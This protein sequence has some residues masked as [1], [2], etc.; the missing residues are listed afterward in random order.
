MTFKSIQPWI[1]RGLRVML[2]LVVPI[3]LVLVGLRIYAEGGREQVTENAYVKT[4][5]IAMSSAVT[6]RV[7]EVFVKDDVRV[8]K[9][10]ALFRIDSTPYELTAA[11]AK[12]Q[13]DVVRTEMQ[14][15]KAEYRSVVV[16]AEE[17]KVRIEFFAKQVE[18]QEKLRE[19]GMSRADQYDEARQ[20]LD[21][22]K[23]R[24]QTIMEQ[25]RRVQASLGGDLNAP[26]EEHPRFKEA[27][28][29]Y[30]AAVFELSK[31][32]VQSLAEGIVSN[33]KL[34]AGEWVNRG[35]T[36]FSLIDTSPPWVEANFKETQLTHMREGQAVTVVADAYPDAEFK[37]QVVAIAPASGAEFAV[38]PPQNA[39][40]NWVKVVQR[41]P[42]RIE[43]QQGG[44]LPMLRAGMTVTASVET[45]HMRGL[46]RNIQALIDKGYLPQFLEP[47]SALA[48]NAR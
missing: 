22:A 19:R 36:V 21:G 4:N 2:V 41:I 24:L 8:N 46:P 17:V 25:G 31:T 18:R 6:G 14:T 40:G 9:G 11:K 35:Q 13:M 10:D 5:I 20:N 3:G 33:M 42:V 34:E 26:V 16:E 32:T 45:G 7:L 47:S 15:L 27:Q 28:A 30:D 1:R 12:A 37:G 29:Q 39:T 23:R 38:L 44:K 48:R 43:V